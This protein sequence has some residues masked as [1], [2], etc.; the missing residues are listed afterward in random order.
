MHGGYIHRTPKDWKTSVNYKKNSGGFLLVGLVFNGSELDEF[1]KGV[2]EGVVVLLAILLRSPCYVLEQIESALDQLLLD[3]AY[4]PGLLQ[5]PKQED[6]V[7][8]PAAS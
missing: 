8:S 4:H 3:H 6:Y 2:P 7:M 5:V 1:A